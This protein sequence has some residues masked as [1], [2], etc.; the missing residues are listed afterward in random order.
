VDGIPNVTATKITDELGIP[1]RNVTNKMLGPVDT[2]EE[3]RL[4]QI[5]QI[6]H[7]YVKSPQ[8]KQNINFQSYYFNSFSYLID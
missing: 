1:V 4:L 3:L 8:K 7:I 5:A 6:W 2:G